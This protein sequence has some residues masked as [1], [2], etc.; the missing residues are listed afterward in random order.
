MQALRSGEQS[1]WRSRIWRK[2]AAILALLVTGGLVSFGATEMIVSYRETRTQIGQLQ[3]AQARQVAQALRAS[4]QNIERHVDAVMALPWSVG[5]WLSLDTR[6]EEYARLL[7]LVPAVESVAFHD[8]AGKEMLMVSRRTLDRV[9]RTATPP[10]S[11]PASSNGGASRVYGAVEYLDGYDPYLVLDLSHPEDAGAGHTRVR[12]AMR[13]LARETAAALSVPG[14]EVYA[15]DANGTIVMHRDPGLMLGRFKP[16]PLPERS[17][18]AAG[19]AGKGLHGDEVLQSVEPMDELH[20]SVVVEQPMATAMEPVWSALRRTGAFMVLG[21]V[22]SGVAALYLAGRLTR[23]IR[24]LYQGAQSIGAGSLSTRVDVRT[25]DELEM[26][27][28]RFNAMA[29]SL[30]E[31]YASLEARVAEKTHDL[32]VA[33]RHKSEFLANMSH[34]LRTPLNAVIG[35]S[36]VLSEQMFGPLNAKQMEYATDIHGSG[37]HLLAL[38]NDILE[39]SKIEAG[40]LELEPSEFDVPAAAQ[41]A[42]TLVRERAVRQGLQLVLQIGPE[43]GTWVAD[44]RR[45]KQILVNLLSNAVKFTPDG[46]QVT[47]AVEQTSECLHVEVADT[48]IGIAAADMELIFEPFRQVGAHGRARA[49]G[50]GLGLSLVRSLVELHGGRLSVESRL[51]EGSR[52]CIEFPRRST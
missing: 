28:T 37:H 8:A 50:T 39:L 23:P 29:N 6:R 52:F 11:S 12:I 17:R 30:E 5:N 19:M 41:T 32:E 45:F 20:W 25:G 2:Q 1:V 4:L 13:A 36:E 38:I 16:P 33:N 47:L 10:A 49:E 3:Q 35:F 42:A 27:A 24:R 22:L 21:L 14:G 51:G 7:R 48:G 26:L 46:G 31:S 18:A 44:P 43:V 40:R 9:A 34:E 15:V